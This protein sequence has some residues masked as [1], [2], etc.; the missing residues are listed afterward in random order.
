MKFEIETQKVK[1]SSINAEAR[2]NPQLL[3]GTSENYYNDCVKLACESSIRK[4]R[5]IILLTGPSS[6]GKT[7]TSIL[8]TNVLSKYHKKVVRVSLDNFY[9]NRDN[10][11]FWEDGSRNYEAVEGLDL[12][13]FS[14]CIDELIM[15]GTA[16]FPIFDFAIGE[17]SHRTF[18]VNYDNDTVLI[19]EGI[20]AL[21]PVFRKTLREEQCMRIY[22]SAHTEFTDD[23]GNI[24]MSS[25]NLR[26]IRRILRDNTERATS[27]DL[28]LD[29]WEKVCLGEEKYINPYRK[30]ADLHIN[31]THYYEPM[32]YKATLIK[33]LSEFTSDIAH[34]AKFDELLAAIEPFE[35]LP[36]GI[37]PKTSLLREF[38]SE[39]QT[40][41]KNSVHRRQL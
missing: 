32:V 29:F 4:R 35:E 39:D 27:A 41:D 9:K 16:K 19:F 3:A 14:R 23:I 25:R 6:A 17:R 15:K 24:V 10:L 5:N 1:I 26:L 28:T 30:N 7:T 37:V 20:H 2:K 13:C 18:K 34:K 12:D 33:M 31:S 21:N 22:V 40:V 8:L 38:I 11:P 36:I